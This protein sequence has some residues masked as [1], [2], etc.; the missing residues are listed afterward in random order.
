MFSTTKCFLHHSL[1]WPPLTPEVVSIHDDLCFPAL[2][3]AIMNNDLDWPA[4]LFASICSL[5]QHRR[6]HSGLSAQAVSQGAARA[7]HPLPHVRWVPDLRQAPRQRWWNGGQEKS[8]SSKL[9]FVH[10]YS[11][12]SK[13]LYSLRYLLSEVLASINSYTVCSS[14]LCFAR[15]LCEHTISRFLK[16]FNYRKKHTEQNLERKEKLKCFTSFS[17]GLWFAC[18]PSTWEKIRDFAD[19][20]MLLKSLFCDII[21]IWG[22]L[23][24]AHIFLIPL[25][26]PATCLCR[27][28]RSWGDWWNLYLQ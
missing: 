22:S 15:I 20:L 18:G 23:R 16:V 7:R 1:F 12:F 8:P 6:A 28:S 10:S 3:A 2:L 25:R 13:V 9:L 14:V 17:V 21:Q 24:F 11:Y 26:W 19:A 5:Q 4:V 27:A